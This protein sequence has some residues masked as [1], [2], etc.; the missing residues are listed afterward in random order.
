[1]KRLRRA[2]ISKRMSPITARRRALLDKA[3]ALLLLQN[4]KPD[5]SGINLKTFKFLFA[6]YDFLK[7]FKRFAFHFCSDVKSESAISAS[8]LSAYMTTVHTRRILTVL[9]QTL[10][11]NLPLRLIL[12]GRKERVKNSLIPMVYWLVLTKL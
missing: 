12:Y 7:L 9:L 1:M 11:P 6:L 2:Q 10:L 5:P 3:H 4:P 8:P